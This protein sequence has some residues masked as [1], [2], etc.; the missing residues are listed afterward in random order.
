MVIRKGQ[1][2]STSVVIAIMKT[3][4]KGPQCQIQYIDK[5]QVSSFKITNEKT[6]AQLLTELKNICNS[7]VISQ[8]S[9]QVLYMLQLKFCI[10]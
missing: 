9:L 6:S 2:S 10:C 7:L 3:Y 1:L 8:I 4:R 5:S